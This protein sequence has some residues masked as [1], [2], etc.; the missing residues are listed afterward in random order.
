LDERGAKAGPVD[1]GRRVH[2]TL[3]MRLRRFETVLF[4]TWLAAPLLVLGLF[5]LLAWPFG[6]V[7][8]ATYAL[9]LALA[10]GTGLFTHWR[11]RTTVV[12]RSDK[13]VVVR[14]QRR[15]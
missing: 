9:M 2:Q 12:E 6:L 13:A 3:K 4:P 14:F 7:E 8:W 15:G 10:F 11:Y 1:D 5:F